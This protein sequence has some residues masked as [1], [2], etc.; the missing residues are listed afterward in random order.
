MPNTPA[1]VGA[2]VVG[3]YVPSELQAE[4]RTVAQDVLA[5]MGEVITVNSEEQLDVLSTVSGSGPAY[6][7]RFI[8]ALEASAVRRGFDEAGARRMAIMTVVGAGKLASLSHEAPSKLRENVTS[9]G[10]T[11]AEALRVMQEHDFMGMMDEAIQAA[12]D[13]NQILADELGKA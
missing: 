13:R 6:V 5:A 2:G 1:L 12:F 9:K 10:G 4:D 8:E 3:L 7:F 11:T